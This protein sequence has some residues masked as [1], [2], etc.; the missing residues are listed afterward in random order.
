MA[1]GG[2]NVLSAGHLYIQLIAH[3][4]NVVNAFF[5]KFNNLLY[6]LTMMGYVIVF[7]GSSDG[8][9]QQDWAYKNKINSFEWLVFIEIWVKGLAVFW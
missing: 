4:S 5:F 3:I 2:S 1:F 6:L 8:D 9:A 7:D